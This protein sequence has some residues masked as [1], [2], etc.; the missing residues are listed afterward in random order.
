[1]KKIALSFLAELMTCSS[2]CA[3][4]VRVPVLRL[5]ALGRLSIVP[6]HFRLS[7]LM[8]LHRP[9]F[10]H[11]PAVYVLLTVTFVS[12][13]VIDNRTYLPRTREPLSS[14]KKSCSTLFV[15]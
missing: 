13:M 2:L 10:I 5:L 8:G 14:L 1:L 6:G 15:I 4:Q 7:Q 12:Y 11:T 3:N 9:T